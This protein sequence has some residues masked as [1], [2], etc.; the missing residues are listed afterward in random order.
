MKQMEVDPE[1]QEVFRRLNFMDR[2]MV[3]RRGRLSGANHAAVL[4]GR[5]T[6]VG[7]YHKHPA[8]LRLSTHNHLSRYCVEFKR[9]E[10]AS[11]LPKHL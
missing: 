2:Y 4:M 6:D 1:A 7:D 8:T 5:V 9:E 10:A 11:N 3:A